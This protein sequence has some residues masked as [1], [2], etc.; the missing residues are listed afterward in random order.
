MSE[1]GGATTQSGI[2]YQNSISALYLGNLIDPA[3]RLPREQVTSVRVEAPEKVDDTVVTY[4]DGHKLFVQAKENVREND[5]AWQKLWRDFKYQFDAA[6]FKNGKDKMLLVVGTVRD[7]FHILHEICNRAS[8]SENTSEFF[9]RLI[10]TQEKIVR[11]LKGTLFSSEPDEKATDNLDGN[12]TYLLSLLKHVE[13]EIWTLKDIEQ[14]AVTRRIPPSNRKQLELFSVLRDKVGGKA[15]VKGTFTAEKLLTELSEIE[16]EIVAQPSTEMLRE[17]VK[18]SGATLKGYKNSFGGTNVHLEREITAEIIQWATE[19]TFENNFAVLL[20]QAGM[21]KTVVSQ[22]ILL[23][24]ENA[25]KVVLTVK[26][27]ALS[28]IANARDLQERLGLPDRVERVLDRLATN[29]RVILLIDQIDA[30]S[31]SLTHDEAALDV[32][33]ELAARAR[34]I[35]NL[36]IIVSCRTF[37]FNNDPRLANLPVNKNFR[38]P[39]LTVDEIKT[40]LER[41]DVRFENLEHATQTL[42]Q[43]PLHLDLFA[44]VAAEMTTET[45]A[46][47]LPLQLQGLN[48][49]QDLYAG[50]WRYVVC[51]ADVR[52]PGVAARERVLQLIAERMDA[53]QEVAVP[54]SFISSLDDEE[55][56]AAT[57][58]L[59]SQGILIPNKNSWNLLHQ[60][61][62]DYCYAKNFVESDKSLYETVRGGEQGLFVRS[63]IV[64]VLNYWRGVSRTD[65]LR[66]LHSFLTSTE[67]RF[68]LRDHVLRWFGALPAPI[69][70]EWLVAQTFLHSAADGE[71]L[72]RFMRGNAGW[73]K[74]LKPGFARALE[75]GD[76]AKIDNEVIPF[77]D[78]IFER[79]QSDI[80]EM[81]RPFL[82]RS[83]IWNKRI[84]R[85]FWN[86]RDWEIETVAFFEEVFKLMTETEK[87]DFYEINRVAE[88]DPKAVCRMV[89]NAFDKEVEQIEKQD[90]ESL[91]LMCLRN[92]LEHLNGSSLVEVLQIVSESESE[93]FL[94]EMLPWLER[95]F[96]L[97]KEPDESSFYFRSDLLSSGFD[98]KVYVV[99]WQIIKSFRTALINVAKTSRETFL[100]FSEI[101]LTM[102]YDTAQRLLAQTFEQE[103]E[104]YAAEALD[105]L[106]ADNRRLMLGA[107]EVFDSRQLI[108]AITPH[109]NQEQAEKLESAVFS[110]PKFI[111]FPYKK[112]PRYAFLQQFYLMHS[113]PP[114]KMTANGRKYLAELQ[115][116]FPEEKI[117]ERPS[118]SEGGFVGSPIF[119]EPIKKMSDAAWLAA[120]KKYSKGVTHKEFL[121]GGAEQL[122]SVLTQE[123]KE[124]PERFYA[125][126]IKMPFDTDPAYVAALINGLADSFAPAERLFEVIRRFS[127]LE[128]E[129]TARATA[130]ALEK[131]AKENFPDDLL[132]I[133]EAKVRG[134][135]GED[136]EGW[137]KEKEEN[138]QNFDTLN[139]SPYISYL[140]SDRGAIF[141]VVMRVLDARDEVES[142]RRKWELLEFTAANGSDALK[143]GVIEELLYIFSEEPERC[144]ILFEDLINQSLVLLLT[145]YALEFIYW[146]TPT[147]FGKVRSFIEAAMNSEHESVQEHAA[148]L[149]CLAPLYKPISEDSEVSKY[150]NDLAN[151]AKKSE[152]AA[153]RRGAVNVYASNLKDRNVRLFCLDGLTAMLGDSDEEVIRRMRRVFYHADDSQFVDLQPFVELYAASKFS[154][155]AERDLAEFLWKHGN[156]APEWSLSIVETILKSRKIANQFS[157][158]GEFYVRL[159]LQIYKMPFVSAATRCQA[160]DSFDELMHHFTYD[161]SRILSEWDSR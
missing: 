70:D 77:L 116:K 42:L 15:R 106:A 50:L 44:R 95:V 7:E 127:A 74:Y 129:K 136:E 131:R 105:F 158:D 119:G 85:L 12:D 37:D 124:E 156:L 108:K 14:N 32:L 117:S 99:L 114:E 6:D 111:G 40:V 68:H 149:A 155:D 28:G 139:S 102:R 53:K 137:H 51:K 76:D 16:V 150:A 112:Y 122:S 31:L 48:S 19:A 65:Y 87:L 123:V 130:S 27:D 3:E 134:A 83:E 79:E 58:W 54:Q 157:R 84:R 110:L 109:L 5:A 143:A 60:T 88:T 66:E 23:G 161:A 56:N 47:D 73:F 89:R 81:M 118:L 90:D 121:K 29:E 141:R 9:K 120:F 20:D 147:Y 144:V 100:E 140:N 43:I 93:Y 75:S 82:G 45:S 133:L 55:L 148:T 97:S 21:G 41:I 39:S 35:P 18:A 62:F 94:R 2:F 57:Q 160:L 98:Y 159:V 154:D 4:A 17:K 69:E 126:T 24:L 104:E 8:T 125:L 113:F 128:N 142:K 107:K 132:D 92:D 26:A 101:L 71:R 115:R 64:Q 25:D 63:Q 1:L 30:L 49:L 61:F 151:K 67:I 52:A 152:K 145:H 59:A 78:F 13:V 153:C 11:R 22:D 10:K 103:P 34:L 33:L 91:G 138:K 46:E 72:R 135:A 146:A 36:Q 86:I 80:I 96:R 38:L